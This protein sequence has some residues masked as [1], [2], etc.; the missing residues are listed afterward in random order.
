MS[1][2]ILGP[3]VIT[4]RVGHIVPI[5]GHKARALLALLAIR[6]DRVVP[7]EQL[8]DELW[9]GTPPTG[10]RTTLHAHI[11]RL[12]AALREAH[13][14][15]ALVTSGCGYQLTISPEELD[16]ARF[17]MVARAGAE[18]ASTSPDIAVSRLARALEE[19]RGSALQG[20]HDYEP[21]FLEAQRLEEL[22]LV[23]V[24]ERWAAELELGGHLL[25]IGQLQR[26]AVDHPFRERLQGL[27]LLA[28]HRSGRQTEALRAYQVAVNVLAEVGLSPGPELRML[29]Q[30]IAA[31]DPGDDLVCSPVTTVSLDAP[32]VDQ[33]WSDALGNAPTVLM[34]DHDHRSTTLDLLSQCARTSDALVL[35]GELSQMSARPSAVVADALRPILPTRRIDEET[36]PTVVVE[37]GSHAM[38][39]RASLDAAVEHSARAGDEALARL[40][41]AEAM[42]HY[43]L[44][45]GMLDLCGSNQR[46]RRTELLL[47]CGRACHVAYELTEALTMFR[48]A[49]RSAASIGDIALLNEAACGLAFA[50]EF[51]MA[52]SETV[53]LLAH[54]LR[55]VPSDSARRVELLAGLART[56]PQDDRRSRSH[57]A[58]AV[59][60][61]RKLG[62][63]RALTIALATWVLVSWD[64]GDADSRLTMIDEA[65]TLGEELAWVDIVVEARNWRAATLLQLGREV[66][67]AADTA[68]L[69]EWARRTGRPFFVAL[70]A[71]RHIG[72]LLDEGRL[73]EAEIALSNPPVGAHSSP[74]FSEAAAAQL[75]LLRLAQG[76]A[77][78][79]LALIESFLDDGQAPFAWRAAHVL[80]L[81][82]TGDHRSADALHTQVGA[83]R[84]APRNWL[85]LTAV[86]LLT[87]ACIALGDRHC[88]PILESALR[89]HRKETVVVAH[90]IASLGPVAP[91]LDALQSLLMPAR[92]DHK[93]VASVP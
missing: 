17:E 3:V 8:E 60:L 24:E 82:H 29:E 68:R 45:L 9:C 4:D 92:P 65:I 81:V 28:L 14:S 5:A 78:E 69:D 44:A 76:R 13:A 70:A 40:G 48:L 86:S 10:A 25:A 57:A 36:K 27:L 59:A 43:R 51:A 30:R 32:T 46:R 39:A 33:A 87:D 34:A 67:A 58:T 26:L 54:A 66:E 19:W 47:A 35:H 49:A 83:L 88:A 64:P 89:E 38:K 1:I 11:S 85:W 93:E 56:M 80:A 61:A 16:S 63:P 22:R 31:Q 72:A 12:R 18:A 55:T 41:Y 52:D 23:A 75:F 15:A 91:R 62:D 2:R 90:G 7:V 50:T 21:L 84:T 77:A 73:D 6:P 53:E 37:S 42:A 20:M 71:M 79:L 74:N